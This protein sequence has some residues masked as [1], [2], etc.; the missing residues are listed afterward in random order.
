MACCPWCIQIFWKWHRKTV[1]CTFLWIKL[2]QS[3]L[4]RVA[5]GNY[6]NSRNHQNNINWL[7]SCNELHVP[8]K[9]KLSYYSMAIKLVQ[10][11]IYVSAFIEANSTW[12]KNNK[13][14]LMFIWLISDSLIINV[15]CCAHLFASNSFRIT[16]RLSQWQFN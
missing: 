2:H 11:A 6:P 9:F 13:L 14:L 3:W 1:S 7:T 8:Q 10:T 12:L 5:K 15:F 16:F 4:T